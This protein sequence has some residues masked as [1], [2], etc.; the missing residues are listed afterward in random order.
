MRQLSPL[1]MLAGLGVVALNLRPAVTSVGPLLQEI[2]QSLGFDRT[3]AGILTTLPVLCFGL[4][5]PVAP[6]LGRRFGAENV[7]FRSAHRRRDRLRDAPRTLGAAALCERRAGR[8]FDRPDERA[9]TR[10]REA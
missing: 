9:A 1:V 7:I 8:S 10:H 3:E 6:V 4:I 5:G 2:V